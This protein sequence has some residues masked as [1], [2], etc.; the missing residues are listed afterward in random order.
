MHLVTI[1]LCHAFGLAMAAPTTPVWTETWSTRLTKSPV[2]DVCVLCAEVIESDSPTWHCGA[3]GQ[4]CTQSFHL[5]CIQKQIAI[6]GEK[7]EKCAVCET[8]F[9]SE[10]LATLAMLISLYG[11]D[12]GDA[13]NNAEG[14][15]V[16]DA[17]LDDGALCAPCGSDAPLWMVPVCHHSEES[18]PRT[19]DIQ[20]YNERRTVWIET[21]T[22]NGTKRAWACK[23]SMR[24][25]GNELP[26]NVALDIAFEEGANMFK[27]C[28]KHNKAKSLL[29][30]LMTGM[31]GHVCIETDPLD[32]V[33]G[34]VGV[35]EPGRVPEIATGCKSYTSRFSTALARHTKVLEPSYGFLPR[36]SAA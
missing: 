33:P 11:L 1:A 3:P 10:S 26:F 23:P 7:G 9:T 29:V 36:I 15:K 34:P 35:L 16:V 13:H 14:G 17:K 22:V 20:I 4:E 21:K 18:T 12:E 31:V 5:K 6:N 25:C 27:K 19:S 8:M 30:D 32:E 2:S 24:S 28:T